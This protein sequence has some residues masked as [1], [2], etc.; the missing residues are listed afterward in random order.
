MPNVTFEASSTVTLHTAVRTSSSVAVVTT[1]LAPSCLLSSRFTLQLVSEE[2]Y[3]SEV[4]LFTCLSTKPVFAEKYRRS[5][6]FTSSTLSPLDKLWADDPKYN[7]NLEASSTFT[8]TLKAC[9]GTNATTMS[10]TVR[11]KLFFIIKKIELSQAK[12]Q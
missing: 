9:I 11:I 10:S 1:H 3:S 6:V 5:P 4:P 8:V 7:V 2:I 12:K